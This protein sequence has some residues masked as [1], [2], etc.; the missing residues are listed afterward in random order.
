MTM[1]IHRPGERYHWT[2][3]VSILGGLNI[4]DVKEKTMGDG[5]GFLEE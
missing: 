3:F 5:L 4:A 1:C 2:Q